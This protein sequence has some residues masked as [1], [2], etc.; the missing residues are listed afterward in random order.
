VSEICEAIWAGW[1]NVSPL[2]GLNLLLGVLGVGLMVR[3]SL[4]AFP[5]GLVAVS[6]QA[7]LFWKVRFYADA[8]LQ[9]FFF[10]CLAY[11]WWHWVKHRRAAAELPVTLMC[12]R[13]RFLG[14]A[15]AS[16]V[17][18]LLG[19]WQ[20]NHTDAARPFRDAF[21]AT[22]SVFAQVLQV[23]KKIENWSVWLAVNAVAI[24]AYWSVDLAFT[25]F[26][27]AIYLGLSV[28]GWREW[29]RAG[30]RQVASGSGGGRP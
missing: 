13:E 14:L 16:G 5:V 20:A 28:V 12:W 18:L 25:A 21:I 15:L 2:D 3:R 26:L 24:S 11:G 4:W 9:V 27:Y 30:Q 10:G 19:F 7:I 29:N 8:Q 22:F 23:R 1:V 17:T 6:V